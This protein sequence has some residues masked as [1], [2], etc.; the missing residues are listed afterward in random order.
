MN[1]TEEQRL[2][3]IQEIIRKTYLAYNSGNLQDVY[4]ISTKGLNLAPNNAELLLF[5]GSILSMST[6]HCDAGIADIN[7][8]MSS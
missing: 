1:A 3:L 5:R 4:D 8:A 7:K 6:G 2:E